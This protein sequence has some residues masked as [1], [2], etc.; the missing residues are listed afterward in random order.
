[1]AMSSM[2]VHVQKIV[3]KFAYSNEDKSVAQE[4]VVYGINH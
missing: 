3:E 1:M 4:R 2:I